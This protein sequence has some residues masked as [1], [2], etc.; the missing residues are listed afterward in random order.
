M[1][2]LPGALVPARMGPG[3]LVFPNTRVAANGIGLRDVACGGIDLVGVAPGSTVVAAYLYWT[4]ISLPVPIPGL[5]D[6]MSVA[7]VPRIAKPGLVGPGSGP[8]LGLVMRPLSYPGVLVGSGADPCWNGGGNFVY[9]ADVTSLVTRGDSF[10]VWLPPGAAGQQNYRDPWAFPFPTGP[11]CEGAS[12]VV[13]YTNPNEFMGT[14]YIYDA[15]LAGNM[16]LGSPGMFWNLAGFFHPGN[17]ARWI[18]IGADGQSGAGYQELH[19]MGLE[20]TFFNGVAI[21]GP[22]SLTDSD[23]NGAGNK[24]LALMWDT[25]GHDVSQIL[26]PFS[27]VASIQVVAPPPSVTTDCLVPVCNVLWMR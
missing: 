6:Q 24:P 13:V 8:Q 10:M 23:W 11:H 16:F 19:A 25:S 4:W 17:E 22:G 5:H 26:G 2:V 20:T 12:L 15:G 1:Q 14:T 18:N 27:N 3:P 21:A 9:R 7:R